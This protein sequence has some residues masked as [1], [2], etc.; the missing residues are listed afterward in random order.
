MC[1]VSVRR[2]WFA[3]SRS[4]NLWVNFTRTCSWI[5]GLRLGSLWPELL[6]RQRIWESQ[7]ED[8]WCSHLRL[9]RWQYLGIDRLYY[10][11]R[12]SSSQICK[13]SNSRLWKQSKLNTLPQ[14]VVLMCNE[15][16]IWS[17]LMSLLK[18]AIITLVKAA[19]SMWLS[20]SRFVH[21]SNQ[22]A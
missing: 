19:R 20:S 8:A 14:S 21:N 12:L 10:R 15:K 1:K 4:E 13:F 17:E 6:W 16:L 9:L 5:I 22:S 7:I 2:W 3:K 11:D 18:T